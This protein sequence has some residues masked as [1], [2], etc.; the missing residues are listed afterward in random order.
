MSNGTCHAIVAA[1]RFLRDSARS[2]GAVA[3]QRVR[4]GAAFDVDF[5]AFQF[6]MQSCFGLQLANGTKPHE[7]TFSA[8]LLIDRTIAIAIDRDTWCARAGHDQVMP[9][10]LP[11]FYITN[12]PPYERYKETVK[13]SRKALTLSFHRKI[14]R[15]EFITGACRY[16]RLP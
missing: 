12:G 14:L 7:E 10:A 6:L 8:I 15:A 4:V 1:D 5:K 9:I 13:I 16:G 11:I 3:K 2:C